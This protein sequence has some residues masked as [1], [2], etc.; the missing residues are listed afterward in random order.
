MPLHK[1]MDSCF[2][3]E[4][5]QAMKENEIFIFFLNYTRVK[6]YFEIGIAIYRVLGGASTR[7]CCYG[8]VDPPG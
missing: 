8:S 6:V 1:F 5:V 4:K 3:T 2:G 7:P